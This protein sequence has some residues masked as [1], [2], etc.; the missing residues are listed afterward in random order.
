MV[1]MTAEEVLHRYEQLRALTAAMLQS[2]RG[3]DWDAL[4]SLEQQ[5]GGL[6]RPLIDAG[7]GPN[8][9]VVQ[10]RRKV[11]VLK[12][13]LHED[14]EIRLLTNDWMNK[15]QQFL[16]SNDRGRMAQRFYGD[17]A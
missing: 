9:S 10:Q 7:G 17:S 1:N 15:L 4:V 3:G 5:C 16:G 12:A 11:E 14:A 6:L 8:L 2:A 13:I